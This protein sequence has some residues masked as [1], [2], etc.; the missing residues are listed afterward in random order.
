MWSVLLK[1]ARTEFEIKVLETT[2]IWPQNMTKLL[3]PKIKSY[4]KL[5]FQVE[6]VLQDVL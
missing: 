3:E 5:L 1:T 2:S 4:F 6:R